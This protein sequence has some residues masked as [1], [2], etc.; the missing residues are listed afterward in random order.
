M[1]LSLEKEIQI[2]IQFDD[3]L[4]FSF[5]FSGKIFPFK[6][7][8]T[9]GLIEFPYIKNSYKELTIN[10]SLN[11]FF[12]KNNVNFNWGKVNNNSISVNALLL[13]FD[14]NHTLNYKD[15]EIW[16]EIFKKHIEI[17]SNQTSRKFRFNGDRIVSGIESPG[18]LMMKSADPFNLKYFQYVL[19]ICQNLDN[20]PIDLE[21]I[22]EARILIEFQDFRRSI[23]DCATAL[24]ITL[25][26]V[27]ESKLTEEGNENF[28]RDI[29]K[30]KYRTL[31][32]KLQLAFLLGII[33]DD[34]Y[35]NDI[36]TLRNMIV[37]KGYTPTNQEAN[38]ALKKVGKL[39]K[40]FSSLNYFH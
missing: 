9:E 7:K 32:N 36:V 28:A 4:I 1:S 12:L 29:L 8:D 30:N 38:I 21:L 14:V 2:V 19:D 35:Q 23:I 20:I 27:C 10:A 31:G 24:E 26:K 33:I 13:K 39:V 18:K 25:T 37:H 5:D 3:S 16:M 34:S 22:N 11:P 6:I 15:I 17:S 40:R